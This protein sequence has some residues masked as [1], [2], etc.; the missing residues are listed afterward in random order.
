MM[1]GMRWI[2]SKTFCIKSAEIDEQNIQEPEFCK[3]L[4]ELGI[5]DITEY[6]QGVQAN[7]L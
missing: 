6:K 7:S 3:I 5:I 2:N 4:N 1:R